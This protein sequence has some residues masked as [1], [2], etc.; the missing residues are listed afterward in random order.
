M[1]LSVCLALISQSLSYS[2]GCSQ[3]GSAALKGLLQR[4]DPV[5]RDGQRQNVS[6]ELP[7]GRNSGGKQRPGF[8]PSGTCHLLVV[9]RHWRD[10]EYFPKRHCQLLSR[11]PQKQNRFMQLSCES[12]NLPITM[13]ASVVPPLFPLR[14]VVKINMGRKRGRVSEAKPLVLADWQG[15]GCTC[16][17]SSSSSR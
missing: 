3:S 17:C 5:S 8:R 10:Q 6:A 7:T 14:L 16:P 4:P 9:V 11:T 15:R 12:M 1:A 2:C 13:E